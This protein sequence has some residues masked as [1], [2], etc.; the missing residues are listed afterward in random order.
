[1]TDARA[2]TGLRHRS[3]HAM[4]VMTI[5]LGDLCK[6]HRIKCSK[7]VRRDLTL[8]AENAEL[9]D[10]YEARVVEKLGVVG[11]EV[12]GGGAEVLY[13]RLKKV[14]KEAADEVLPA[15]PHHKNGAFKYLDDPV[16]S[17]LSKEQRKLSRRIYHLVDGMRPKL[18]S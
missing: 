1:M 13:E 10:A 14:V 18:Q 7:V 2:Y 4:V 15:V 17:E 12:P 3:D 8:L 5:D 6:I 9:R 11:A 16:L